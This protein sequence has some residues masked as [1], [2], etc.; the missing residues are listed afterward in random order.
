MRKKTLWATNFCLI[1]ALVGACGDDG[2]V[3]GFVDDAGSRADGEAPVGD[4]SGLPDDRSAPDASADAATDGP[5]EPTTAT[6]SVVAGNPATGYVDGVGELAR[7]SGPSG[8]AV[9]PDGSAMLISDTFNAVLRRLDLATGAVTTVAG[10]AHV[11]AVSDGIGTA[12]R[13]SSP[14]GAAISPD[15]S[16]Y[17]FADGPTVRKY[18]IATGAVT[19][20][21]GTPNQNG[22]VDGVGDAVRFGFLLHDLE[23]SA[24]GLTVY[25]ADRSNSRIR[26]LDVTTGTVSTLAGGAAGHAD[27][28]G[29]AARFNFPGGIARVDSTL[30]V[31]DTFNAVLRTVDLTTGQVSTIAGMP[32]EGGSVDGTGGAARFTTPQGL[33]VKGSF[34]YVAGTD[35]LLRRVARSNFAVDTVVGVRGESFTVDGIAGAARLGNAFA[36]PVAHPTT[37]AILFMDRSASSVRRIEIGSWAVSTVAGAKDPEVTRDGSLLSSRFQSPWGLAAN[38]A[39]TILFVA[40]DVAHVIRKVDLV[41]KAVTTFCGAIA[42]SGSSDGACAS[43]RFDTPAALAWDEAAGHLYV[44][45]EGNLSIRDIDVGAGTVSTLAGA[46]SEGTMT[47]GTFAATRF[48]G[49]GPLALDRAGH[50]LFVGDVSSSDARVRVLDLAAKTSTTLVGGVRAIAAPVDGAIASAT[51]SNPAGLAFDEV[52]QRLFFAESS[53]ATVRVVDLKGGTVATVAGLDNEK[54][55][56]DGAFAAARFAGPRGLAWRADETALYVADYAANTIRKLDMGAQTVG[57]WLGDPSRAGG[58][59]AGQTVPSANATLYFPVAPVWTGGKLAFLGEGGVY[60]ATPGTP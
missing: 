26:T 51:L 19:T 25:I 1:A 60:L 27:G 4:A 48:A 18:D 55:P 58:F 29:T 30:Y 15:G 2:E 17:W 49:P 9:L 38:A 6:L 59:A 23:V 37:E 54:G 46:A 20:V 41:A 45:D 52:G 35:G 3:R 32:G 11:A 53:R 57:T 50:R 8:A 56:A 40:D 43:A 12:A 24:D 13:V 10:R 42:E 5:A 16:T 34:L 33:A 31:A 36:P 39:G 44:V 21:A 28:V 22:F 7:F 14:R 47:D